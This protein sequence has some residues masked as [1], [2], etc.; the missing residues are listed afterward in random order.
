MYSFFFIFYIVFVRFYFFITL[1]LLYFFLVVFV[2]LNPL[3]AFVIVYTIYTY[4]HINFI[5]RYI[6]KRF[7]LL[8]NCFACDCFLLQQTHA[9]PPPGQ[10]IGAF[11]KIYF[12]DL[13]SYINVCFR[14][15]MFIFLFVIFL[16]FIF[17]FVFLYI[18]FFPG[19][20]IG[21]SHR[22]FQGPPV[23]APLIISLYVSIT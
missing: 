20:P 9:I 13:S 14:L 1:L 7:L 8:Y 17:L 19:Q 3:F 2:F 11:G 10:P 12:F 23:R 5:H 21:A 18:S 4:I 22:D 16:T 6:Y 15:A